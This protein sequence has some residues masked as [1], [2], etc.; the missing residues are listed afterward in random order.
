M[1][2]TIWEETMVERG[3]A[4]KA[5]NGAAARL[6]QHFPTIADLRTRARRRRSRV[7]EVERR[8]GGD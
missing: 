1:R 6:R 8:C 2:A 5:E 7:V 4:E 3:R